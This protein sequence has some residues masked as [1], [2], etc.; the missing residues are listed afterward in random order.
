MGG[1][2]GRRACRACGGSG[3]GHGLRD[4]LPTV[5]GLEHLWGD[6]VAHCPYCHGHEFTGKPVGLLGLRP[7][8]R[9]LAGVMGPV[10]SEV[11]VFTNGVA[12]EEGLAAELRGRAG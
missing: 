12:P 5:P 6:V 1:A 7:A 11:L 2:H 8:T 10:A 3:P 9:P 4:T